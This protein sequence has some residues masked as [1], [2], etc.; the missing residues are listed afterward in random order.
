MADY[1]KPLPT[2]NADTKPF[3]DACKLHELRLPRCTECNE[4]FY[5][6]QGVCP[7]CLSTEL[8]WVKVSG[9]G[10]VYSLSVVHQNK[11]PGFK[12]EGPYVLAYVTLDEGV[13]MLTNV[14][15]AADPYDVEIGM[16]VE[17]VFEDATDAI[18]IPKFRPSSG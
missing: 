14:V 8:E 1:V 2:V 17:V 9:K 11:S 16:P 6:P 15:G 13:L 5:P 18:S 12:D 3:W 7:R 4:L 10:A